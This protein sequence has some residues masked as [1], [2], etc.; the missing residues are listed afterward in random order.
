MGTA[1]TR[2][3]CYITRDPYAVLRVA[4]T[5]I[6]LDSVVLAFQ[7]GESPESICQAYPPLTLEQVYG[8]ITYYLAH[9]REVDAYLRNQNRLWQ[10][11]RAH[12]ER[13]NAPFLDRLRRLKSGAGAP[14]DEPPTVES[15]A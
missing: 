6:S 4:G 12:S 13:E 3:D 7:Q 10:R 8:A 14:P 9:D 15:P 11:G 1:T 5:P 2:T